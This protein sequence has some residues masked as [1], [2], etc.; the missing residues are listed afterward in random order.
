MNPVYR[1]ALQFPRQRLGYN[2]ACNLK[3][4]ARSHNGSRYP[5]SGTT[6]WRGA[7][8]ACHFCV[9]SSLRLGGRIWAGATSGRMESC[10]WSRSRDNGRLV[11][12]A[13]LF[14]S[15]DREHEPVLALIGSDAMADYLDVLSRAGIRRRVRRC[16]IG[17]SD[18]GRRASAS[19]AIDRPVQSSRRFA[20]SD[21]ILPRRGRPWLDDPTNGRGNMPCGAART[22]LG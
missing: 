14:A 17:P 22:G 11:A 12:A 16:T 13:P 5:R 7:W 20:H 21:R 2:H 4:S 6:C 9:T 15:V 10:T 3:S 19:L 8:S 1:R 18:V